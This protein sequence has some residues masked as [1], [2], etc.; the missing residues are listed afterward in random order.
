[1]PSASTRCIPATASGDPAEALYRGRLPAERPHRQCIAAVMPYYTVST[2]SGILRRRK[3]RGQCVLRVP[4]RATCSGA[5]Y[6][7]RRRG[8]PDGPGR[9]P[10]DISGPRMDALA[11]A[12]AW[13]VEAAH[14][15]RSGI[16]ARPRKPGWISSAATATCRPILEAYRLGCEKYG[17][18]VM[19]ARME[20][21]AV[22]LLKNIFRC[23]LFEK[24]LPRPRRKRSCGGL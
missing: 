12:T 4:D 13:G 8:G 22:R 9:D 1:M 21:S 17:E 16:Y 11:G 19:R 5:R 20:R 15:G 6:R 24:P 2:G 14:R 7:L 18:P 3:E 10:K 23:G